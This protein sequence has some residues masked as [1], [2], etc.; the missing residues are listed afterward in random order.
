MSRRGTIWVGGAPF[1]RW[2]RGGLSN[3]IYFKMLLYHS[4]FTQGCFKH[5]KKADS[6]A[7]LMRKNYKKV[8]R[9]GFTGSN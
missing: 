8:F 3:I 2:E 9:N 4:R 5:V 6:L 1:R 7:V